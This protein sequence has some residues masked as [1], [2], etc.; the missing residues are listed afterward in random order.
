MSMTL[1]KQIIGGGGFSTKEIR[2]STELAVINALKAKDDSEI[3]LDD[4]D[5]EA[6]QVFNKIKYLDLHKFGCLCF[7]CKSQTKFFL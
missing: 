4:L 3:P 7:S 1:A 6:R 5:K 2:G